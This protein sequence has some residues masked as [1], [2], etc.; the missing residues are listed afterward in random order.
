MDAVNRLFDQ[1]P[2]IPTAII[3]VLISFRYGVFTHLID[4]WLLS[5]ER[6]LRPRLRH[7]LTKG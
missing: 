1:N 7:P 2:L 5:T 3:G 6:Q 4:S